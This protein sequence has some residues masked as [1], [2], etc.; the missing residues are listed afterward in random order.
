M[1]HYK[2]YKSEKSNKIVA[3]SSFAGKTIKG[4][5][6]CD[7]SDNFSAEFGAKLASARCNSKVAS[8]RV[9]HAA[10]KLIDAQ[11][12]LEEAQKQFELMSAYYNDS[13]RRS[14]EAD[15]EVE[16]ILASIKD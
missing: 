8:K 13:I 10:K 12:A 6:K 1:C 16:S 5:A 15:D 4:V 9:K 3:L 14:K 11:V 2:I 7:P